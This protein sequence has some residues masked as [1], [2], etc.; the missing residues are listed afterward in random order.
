MDVADPQAARSVCRSMRNAALS[1]RTGWGSTIRIFAG[2]VTG[3]LAPDTD[4]CPVAFLI[5]G[6]DPSEPLEEALMQLHLSS[7]LRFAPI[8]IK[9]RAAPEMRLRRS[10]R[11]AHGRSARRGVVSKTNEAPGKR[12][13]LSHGTSEAGGGRCDDI[14][15]IFVEAATR[16]AHG[17]LRCDMPVPTFSYV[18]W[19]RTESHGRLEAAFIF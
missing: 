17:P 1:R 13:A 11:P 2:D 14:A 12:I 16:E 7:L 15:S 6:G 9:T 5:G 19:S 18:Q 10:R 8:E 3:T 4:V